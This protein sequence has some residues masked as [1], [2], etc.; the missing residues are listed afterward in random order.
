MRVLSL[1]S[2]AGGMDLGL[3]S[4]GHEIVGMCEIDQKARSVLAR[5]WPDVPL[6]DDVTTFET[7]A[8]HGRVDLVAGGSPCQ[9]LS[10]AGNRR[11]LDGQ[12]SGLFWHQC[13]IA[14]SVA[15]PWFLW[16]NVAGALSSNNG[17]DFAAVLW[18]ITGTLPAVPDG[19]WRSAGVCVGPK[20]TAVWRLLD[21]QYFGVPQ[22]RRRIF[23]VA[24]PRNLCG[25]EIL[26]ES[27]GLR[28]DSAPRSQKKEDV[29]STVAEGI[30]GSLGTAH[31]NSL[32]SHGAYIPVVQQ[33]SNTDH[34]DLYSTLNASDSVKWGSNQW[35]D[36][37]KAILVEAFENNS[38][39]GWREGVAPIQA[40]GGDL[41]GESET[42]VVNS[43]SAECFNGDAAFGWRSGVG[44]IRA[45]NSDAGGHGNVVV[46]DQQLAFKE[47]PNGSVQ[48]AEQY[49]TLQA[50]SG[51]GRQPQALTSSGVRRLT[52]RECERLMGWPDDWTRYDADGKEQAD[53]HRYKQCGNGV[54][55]SV[56]KWI[57]ER[58]P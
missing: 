6:H 36:E 2:G 27:E 14:D 43:T 23:V 20:R 15:A 47:D 57:G 34:P 12:R 37:G 10:V 50:Q 32:D 56:A 33:S 31:R 40:A 46:H 22:R 3:E 29:A 16:E 53:S 7:G 1:F 41:G 5:H 38:N 25:P 54:V 24:G 28:G 17:A 49:P 51:A 4:A 55:S 8:W 11:G 26:L 52:P 35:V 45:G 44:P 39:A 48:L 42:L 9:D 58:L 21:A 18:G 13:R 30:A 19:G